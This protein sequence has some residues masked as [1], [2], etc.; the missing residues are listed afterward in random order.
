MVL[1]LSVVAVRRGRWN[2][3]AAVVMV[4]KRDLLGMVKNGATGG[5]EGGHRMLGMNAGS[6][7]GRRHRGRVV[8]GSSGSVGLLNGGGS[9]E[10]CLGRGRVGQKGSELDS[11]SA[12][13][14]K[15]SAGQVEVV[16]V[17]GRWEHLQPAA[18]AVG[19][20]GRGQPLQVEGSSCRSGRRWRSDSVH[21][22]RDLVVG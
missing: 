19:H 2:V 6:K 4:S 12:E 7:D 21:L 13:L 5:V 9:L 20:G 1:M 11:G 14:V 15:R 17:G 18:V 8:V 10:L 3:G 16:R 22:Q